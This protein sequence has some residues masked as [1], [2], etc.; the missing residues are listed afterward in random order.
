MY[1]KYKLDYSW[2]KVT[3]KMQTIEHKINSR[4]KSNTL[5]NYLLLLL[6]GHIL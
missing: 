5:N 4:K 2:K 6:R 1:N 3:D